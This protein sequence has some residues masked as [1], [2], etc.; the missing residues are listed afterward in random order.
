MVK[1]PNSII[2]LLSLHEFKF[3]EKVEKEYEKLVAEENTWPKG[4]FK[5]E[6]DDRRAILEK[7]FETQKHLI[8]ILNKFPV[9]TQNLGTFSMR[10]K[11][12]VIDNKLSQ[13]ERMIKVFEMKKVFLKK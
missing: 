2:F 9:S 4:S 3:R 5:L 12:A 7:L 11:K 1:Y 10:S 8:Y 13:L 6:E